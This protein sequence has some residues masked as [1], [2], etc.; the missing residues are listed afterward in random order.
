[1]LKVNGVII[2]ILIKKKN[3]IR[4][5]VGCLILLFCRVKKIK[6]CKFDFKRNILIKVIRKIVEKDFPEKWPDILSN[7]KMIV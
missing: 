6:L 3:K 4:L 1:M 5:R 7:I 2:N